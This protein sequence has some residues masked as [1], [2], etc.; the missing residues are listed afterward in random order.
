MKL[1]I[2]QKVFSWNSQFTVKDESGHDRYTVEGKVFSLGHKLHVCDMDGHEVA[3]IAQEL[4]A[5]MPRY[6]VEIP[7]REPVWIRKKFTWIHPKYEMGGI[8]W[9]V[10][11]FGWT[12][13]YSILQGKQKV[14]DIRKEILSWGDA[15]AVTVLDPGQ[16]ILALSV[17][18]VI[19][20][21]LESAK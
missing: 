17:A 1:Y 10:D 14:A 3:Y 21:V 2:K 11:G 13:E 4:N 8:D 7:G 9:F 20:C 15:Y 16:E 5:W 18:L 19:D 12:H 6:R